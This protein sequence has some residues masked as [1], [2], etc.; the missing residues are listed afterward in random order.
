MPPK[1]RTAIIAMAL[2]LTA[3]GLFRV[4]ARELDFEEWG[5]SLNPPEGF[6][7]LTLEEDKAVLSDPGQQAYINIKIYEAETYGSAEE[8]YRGVTE[9]L[10][11]EGEAYR[12]DLHGEEIVFASLQFE[13]GGFPF[14]GYGVF[15]AGG[16]QAAAVL[17]HAGQDDFDG[18]NDYLLSALDSLSLTPAGRLKPGPVS[19]F[20]QYSQD[21]GA[22]KDYPLRFP[23]GSIDLE[24]E[25]GE[26]EAARILIE[27][28]ARILADYPESG[29]DVNKAWSRFYRLIH[30][31]N[32]ARLARVGRYLKDSGR[33]TGA[34]DT[35]TAA[36]LLDWIQ[37]FVYERT[38]GESDLVSPLACL[39]EQKGDCDSRGLLYIILLDYLGIDSIL[40]VS[41]VYSHAMV[42]VDV[43]GGGARIDHNGKSYLVA[44]TTEEVDIGM[45][46]ASMADP[47]GWVRI[48]FPA[49]PE[50]P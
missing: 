15:H 17:V 32:D 36:A 11:A 7:F 24:L 43:A 34:D 5:L 10:G 23:G 18:W 26:L 20:F 28:E 8:C 16:Q 40:M 38:W 29:L 3:A 50:R 49:A 6:Q 47:A 39:A 25:E 41:S 33:F 2:L 45:V 19:W 48:D 31:D 30:R 9:R 1:R 46:P 42:G 37:G 12:I 13:T 35:E 22:V 14:E 4:E 27:R 21:P 44:E